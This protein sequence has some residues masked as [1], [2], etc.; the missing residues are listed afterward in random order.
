MAALKISTLESS[1]GCLH[2]ELAT[3]AATRKVGEVLGRLAKPGDLLGLDGPLGAGKTCLIGGLG[4]GLKVAG[5]VS[6]PTFT[7]IN[8][9]AGRL[10][11]YHVDLYRLTAADE[12]ME[13]GL[14]EAAE[15]GGVLAVEWLSRFPDALPA[16][17][18]SLE[19]ALLPPPRRG[20]RLMIRAG[21]ARAAER[22]SQLAAALSRPAAGRAP[23][24]PA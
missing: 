4:R 18:L 23:A 13:L 24:F 6:S 17:R 5:P 21:G 3:A 12:L 20:R 1:Y 8:Q 19:L 10:P 2:L 11:L 9:Y 15:S 14:W 7:L 22:L 16:D